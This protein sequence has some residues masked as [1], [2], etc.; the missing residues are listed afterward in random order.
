MVGGRIIVF[1]VT[2]LS[3]WTLMHLYAFW[4]LGSLP[5]LASIPRW[6]YWVAGLLLW[7]SYPFARYLDRNG[8]STELS[9]VVEFLGATWMGVLFLLVVAL[10]VSDLITLFGLWKAAVLPARAIA[11]GLALVLSVVGMVQGNRAPAVQAVDVTLPGLPAQLDGLRLVQLSDMHLGT[12]LGER[13]LA[14]RISQ[15]RMLQPDLIAI[16]GDLV[17][18]NAR[19]VERLLPLLQQLQAPLGVYAVTGNHEFYAGLERSVELLRQAGFTVLRDEQVEVRPGLVVAGVDDL[20]ARRQYGIAH[21]ALERALSPR[22]SGA[23]VLLSHTPWEVER[24]AELGAQLM[25]SGHTHDGQIWPFSYLVR[26]SYPY[27][28]GTYQVSGLTLHVNRGTGTWGPR[29]RLWKPAEVTLITLRAA[30]AAAPT[31]HH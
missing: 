18:G 29:L 31:S 10:L 16:T 8:F 20:T 11:A 12:I 17:D 13:W 27:L 15:V 30:G 1:F 22:P 24:A 4:R 19:H 23:C 28:G 14:A 25:L 5:G 21:R 7:W 26:L 3:V 6:A 2:V 9:R